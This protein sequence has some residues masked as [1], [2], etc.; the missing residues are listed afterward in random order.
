MRNAKIRFNSNCRIALT[1]IRKGKVMDA[2][3]FNN[4]CI[5]ALGVL[6]S[7]DNYDFEIL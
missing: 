3:I 2:K 7:A 1:R 6:I 4:G 5:M